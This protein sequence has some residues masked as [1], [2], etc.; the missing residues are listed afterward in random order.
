MNFD[1]FTI[2]ALVDELNGKLGSGKIQDTLEIGNHAIGFEIYSGQH[3]HYLLISADPQLA[4]LHLVDEK[5]RRGLETPSPLGLLLRRNVE[6]A[7][8]ESFSQPP[9][10]RVVHMAII[11]AEGEFN[12]IIEPMERRAN[13]LLVE[14]GKI[15]DCMRRVG[16][17]DNR[18]RLSLPGH[19]YVPP[20]PQVNKIMP[21]AITE[22]WLSTRF[23]AEPGKVAWRVLTDS[24]LGFSPLLA[25]ETIYRAVGQ[26]DAK[27]A[28]V[29]P[30]MLRVVLDELLGSLLAHRWEAGITGALGAVS[31]YSVYE[32]TH[33]AGWHPVESPNAAIAAYYGAPVGIEAYDAAKQPV[34]ASIEAAVEKVQ[35]KLDSLNRSAYDTATMDRLRM[36]GELLL[37]YQY[38]IAPGEISYAAEYDYDLPPLIIAIDPTMTP[39]DNAKKYF[40]DYDHTRKAMAEVPGLLKNVQQEMDYLNQLRSD[41]MMAANWPEIGEVQTALHAGGYTRALSANQPKGEKSAPLRVTTPDGYVIWIGRNARQNEEV[42][43]GKGRPEDLWLHARGIPGAHVIIKSAGRAVPSVVL[44]RAGE[45]A[46]F[47]SASRSEGHV[48]VDVTERRYVRKI[49][50]G[51]LGMVT[52]RNESPIEATPRGE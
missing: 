16:P 36:S 45:L 52:Y 29:D 33:I 5:L 1:V 51:K 41:L 31:S 14:D 35:R 20:P 11:G 23:S 28:Q 46:A 2:S 15:L 9:Y 34:F 40:A 39:L 26:W 43:F 30:L 8:I 6:G 22:E 10:E 24:L 12:L 18:V 4:R 32:I 25:K 38:Q 42:T 44:Q 48:L 49:N 37:A 27:S 17:S 19:R 47:Y 13:I 7:R 3:R 21:E 50:G